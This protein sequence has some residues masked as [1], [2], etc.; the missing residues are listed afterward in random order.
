MTEDEKKLLQA[1]HRLEEAEAR[2]R[3]KERKER[4]RRLIQEG[5]ILEKLLPQAQTMDL[6]ALE[7]YLQTTLN[8]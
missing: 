7:S 2:S 3:E 8:V 4:T 1:K 5:A 6:S